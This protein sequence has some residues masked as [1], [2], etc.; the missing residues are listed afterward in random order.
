MKL[1]TRRFKFSVLR[2]LF[3]TLLLSFWNLPFANSQQPLHLDDGSVLL[4]DFENDGK[5]S[6]PH[7]WYD[8]DGNKK[9]INHSKDFVEH[10]LYEVVKEN[11]NK[12]L[13][14][15]GT[16]AKHI[17]LPL[18]NENR[19]NIY[20]INIYETPILS[21]KVRAHSL[22]QNANEKNDNS[23]DSVASLY[24]VFDTG[25]IALFKKVPKTIRYTW[26]T[27]LEKGTTSSKLFGNQQIIVVESGVENKGEWVTFERNI[28]DD[29]RRRFGDD[30]PQT[31][32]AILI[33]SDGNSTGSHVKAD[34]DDIILKREN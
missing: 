11:D 27:T 15:E 4:E 22:P 1:F 3:L 29:Y 34:Y 6:L 20:D 12:F 18:V 17:S 28:V 32:L 24:V 25:R 30:P 16:T 21:W 7:K 9:L 19:D 31:P 14:Y 10:Y 5:G 26:S 33:L 13:R 2:C 23:N 8:R